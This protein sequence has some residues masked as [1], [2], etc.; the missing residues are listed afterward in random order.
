MDNLVIVTTSWDDGYPADLKLAEMLHA[1]DVPATF[2]VPFQGPEGKPTLSIDRLRALHSLGFEIGG[3][4][5]SHCVLTEVSPSRAR[6][7]I[8]G[9]KR[10]LEQALGSEVRM[11][12]YPCGRFNSKIVSLVRAAGYRGARTTRLLA[13]DAAPPPFNMPTTLQ[14]VPHHQ[15]QYLK[16][17]LRRRQWGDLYWYGT[18]LRRYRDW[19]DLGKHLFDQTLRTG[20]IWH[21]T[22]HSW[23]IEALGLWPALQE[24]LRYVRRRARVRYV[25]NSVALDIAELHHAS[26]THLT[27]VN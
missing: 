3:H 6:H 10:D 11:F 15:I 1:Y 17:V 19:V 9:C 14:A 21:L 18:E 16:N 27:E 20:G 8:F 12:S 4:T 26:S 23:E 22:G 7:E 24:L 13:I 5:L 25:C 2:Y